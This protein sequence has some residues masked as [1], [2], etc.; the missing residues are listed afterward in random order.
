METTVVL[1]ITNDFDLNALYEFLQGTN[2]KIKTLEES[3][4]IDPALKVFQYRPTEAFKS[5]CGPECLNRLGYVSISFAYDY[6]VSYAKRHGLH[7]YN[8]IT[9]DATLMNVLNTSAIKLDE[10]ELMDLLIRYFPKV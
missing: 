3:S 2:I 5:F 8:L 1:T 10:T 9:L 7:S 4:I 6:I